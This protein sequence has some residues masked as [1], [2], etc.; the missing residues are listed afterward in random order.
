[1]EESK[2]LE[3]LRRAEED[4]EWIS[5]GYEELRTK[6]EGKVLTVKDKRIIYMQIQ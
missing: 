3:I 4:S 1:M 2:V 5:E 6:Y